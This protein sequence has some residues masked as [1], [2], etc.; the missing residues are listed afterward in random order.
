MALSAALALLTVNL[1]FG[2]MTKAAPQLNIFAIG[3]PISLIAGL[4]LLWLTLSGFT[5][6]FD[7]QMSKTTEIV[8]RLVKL[9][10]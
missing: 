5:G 1:T 6:H 7:S 4:L 8:C 10:C 2:I 9:E 3:F